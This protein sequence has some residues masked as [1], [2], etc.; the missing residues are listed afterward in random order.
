MLT[1]KTLKFWVR[2]ALM[3]SLWI[4]A[5]AFT[6][7]KLATVTPSLLSAGAEPTR[8]RELR[9]RDPE[10]RTHAANRPALAP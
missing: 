5:A 3:I 1:V 8:T 10:A 9:R 4:F 2:P 7:S 6:L